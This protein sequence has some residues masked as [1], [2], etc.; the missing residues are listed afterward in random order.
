MNIEK[1]I[2]RI[3]DAIDAGVCVDLFMDILDLLKN[4]K[5]EIAFLKGMQLQTTHNMS[6]EDIGNAVIKVLGLG[7]S[8]K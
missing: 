1:V 8:A 7:R 2:D 6:D 3:Y 5:E 4:Q